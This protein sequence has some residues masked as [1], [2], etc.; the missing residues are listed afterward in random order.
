VRPEVKKGG[1]SEEERKIKRSGIL[2]RVTDTNLVPPLNTFLF[3]DHHPD[4]SPK[5]DRENRYS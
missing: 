4:I 5:G 1:E 2:I 3:S